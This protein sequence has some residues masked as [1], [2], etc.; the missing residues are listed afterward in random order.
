MIGVFDSGVGGF[1]SL[2]AI[3]SALPLVDIIYLADRENAPYGTKK[4]RELISLVSKGID[5][6]LCRGA[7]RVLLACCT[8]ST[9]WSEL[10]PFYKLRSM[11]IIG[12]AEKDVVGD[13]KTILVIATERTVKD[14]AFGRVIKNK[15]PE[16]TVIEI[17]MQ[18]LVLAVENGAKAGDLRKA[19][20]LEIEKIKELASEY[21]PDALVLGC[22][23]F[24][25]AAG[26]IGEA[27][28]GVKIINT[29]Y[30]GGAAMAEELLA[31]GIKVRERGKLIYM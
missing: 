28:P 16:T 14:G 5:R 8:A 29:A 2:S 24:S 17:P 9:V 10:D 21:N 4:K 1:N 25:S 18:S 3:K 26:L 11:P 20:Y 19:T 13:E 27:L 15:S 30:L 23:H 12:C 6:L 22:T 31:S 7:G